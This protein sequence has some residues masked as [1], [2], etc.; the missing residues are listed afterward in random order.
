MSQQ[1]RPGFFERKREFE[2]G[3]FTSDLLEFHFQ[4]THLKFFQRAV[5][6]NKHDL[7]ERHVVQRPLGLQ[8]LHHAFEREILVGVGL[9]SCLTDPSQEL[10]KSRVARKTRP[11]R[12]SINEEAN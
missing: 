11:Q 6:K 4:I 10:L 9:Q 12:Q 5:L 1:T 8:L 7:G 3:K 2:F